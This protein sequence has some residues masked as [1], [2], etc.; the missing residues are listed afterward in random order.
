MERLS[1]IFSNIKNTKILNSIIIIIVS[2]ILYKGI[3]YFLKKGEER[4][5]F[6]LFTSKKSKT[7]LRLVKN[8][9]RYIFII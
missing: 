8:V 4:D 7:Y 2:I 1:N 3:S 6:K 5:R 9:I